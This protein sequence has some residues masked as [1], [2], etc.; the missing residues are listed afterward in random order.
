MLIDI[1]THWERHR[2]A[3]GEHPLEPWRG[4]LPKD[5][6]LLRFAIGH[7]LLRCLP[8]EQQP[9]AEEFLPV[10]AARMRETRESLHPKHDST[11]SERLGWMDRIGTSHCLVNPG[12]YFEELYFLG[13]ERFAEGHSALQQLPGRAA[14]RNQPTA[15]RGDDRFLRP[16]RGGRGVGALARPGRAGLFPLHRLWT[17]ARRGLA[18]SP[19]LG[20]CVVDG[21]GPGDDARH[22]RREYLS[23]LHGLGGHRLAAT[24][25]LRHPR[26]W[27]VW[28]TP[29]WTARPRTC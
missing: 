11:V 24:G 20:P 7:D 9:S 1:D 29:R 17:A 26:V 25:E 23:R 4:E 16:G 19:R 21:H 15:P 13:P 2:Y 22:P 12:A 6:E 27:C 28:R 8:A 10:L 5:L 18:G 14:R 3:P